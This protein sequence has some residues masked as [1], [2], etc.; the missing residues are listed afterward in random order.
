VFVDGGARLSA[1]ASLDELADLTLPH[2]LDQ[3][4]SIERDPLSATLRATSTSQ[5]LQILGDFAGPV[6][7]GPPGAIGIGFL[8]GIAPSQV[9][10]RCIEG[11]AVLIDGYHRCVALLAAGVEFVPALVLDETPGASPWPRDM[12]AE[13]I[14]LGER[15]PYVADYLDDEVSVSVALRHI[16]RQ[17]VLRAEESDLFPA[18]VAGTTSWSDAAE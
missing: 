16:G 11:R 10:V 3:V 4:P 13:H 12:L 7:G 1:D 15:A 17:I 18:D 5:N 14:V 2:Q 9:R 8:V 6:P